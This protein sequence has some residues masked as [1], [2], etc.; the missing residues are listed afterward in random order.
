MRIN[1][2]QT[3]F[4]EDKSISLVKESSSNYPEFQSVDSPENCAKMMESVFE[5]SKLTEERFWLI[6]LNGARK[7]AGLFE[8]SRGTLMSSL[9]HPR[10]VFQRAILAGAASIIVVHNH[11]SGTLNISEQD[12]EVTRTIKAAGE[13]LGIGLDDHL[14]IADG[15]FISAM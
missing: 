5:A 6:A 7:V 3:R 9:V 4:D 8:V 2:Y 12:R 15:T 10:E 13:L 14:I 11:P 1:I